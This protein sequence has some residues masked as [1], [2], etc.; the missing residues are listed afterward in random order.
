MTGRR[1]ASAGLELGI[2][3]AVA[4][5]A[6]GVAMILVAASGAPP[7]EAASLFLEGAFG[8]P[9]AVAR[10]VTKMVP[11]VLVA[12]GWIVVYTAGRFHV[13]FPGQILLGGVC[14]AAV[15]LYVG[16]PAFLLLPLCVLAGVA[17]GVAYSALVGW[18]WAK[19]GVNE[20]LSTLLLNFV[21]IQL[22]AWLVRAPMQEKSG[23][24]PQT[25]A[26]PEAALWPGFLGDVSLHWDVVLIP[27]AVL[28]IAFVMSRTT[29]GFRVRLVGANENVARHA[30]TSPVR[31]GVI[32][33]LISGVLAGLAGSSLILAGET[34]GMTDNFDAGYGFQGIAVALLA[35]NS[36]LGCIPAALLFAALRQ[37]GGIVEAQLGVSSAIVGITQG[38]VITF[39][40]AA[41][42]LVYLMRQRMAA[43]A[44]VA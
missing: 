33:I 40:L 14:S 16:L 24:L 26:L 41:T 18:L 32:A 25:D 38:I 21:V 31:T 35:R 1:W 13:G 10:T 2:A 8:D 12:L 11:L 9:S 44:R 7:G 4:L 37:G 22:V 27:V 36:P 39:V 3:C 20:I 5:M 34:P 30:G 23:S 42:S 15:A 17:G 28:V 19:R 43:S 29:L 6:L